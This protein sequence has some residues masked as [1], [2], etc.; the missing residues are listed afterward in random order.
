MPLTHSAPAAGIDRRSQHNLR[1]Q[2]VA[3]E[4]GARS[5]SELLSMQSPAPGGGVVVAGGSSLLGAGTGATA[6]VDAAAAAATM[7]PWL[8]LGSPASGTPRQR[9]VTKK[10]AEKRAW[11]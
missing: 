6:D 1:R 4:R 8:V 11:D 3:N 10:G 7:M 2:E 5:N 9:K